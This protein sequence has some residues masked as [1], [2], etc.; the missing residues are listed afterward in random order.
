MTMS[1]VARTPGVS[2]GTGCVMDSGTVM[3]EGMRQR[4]SARVS[5][6]CYKDIQVESW[7]F[8]LVKQIDVHEETLAIEFITKGKFKYHN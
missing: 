8:V 1:S 3:M 7:N 2:P 5:N 6:T 4:D